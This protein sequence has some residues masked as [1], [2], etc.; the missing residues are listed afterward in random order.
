MRQ[1][2]STSNACVGVV[3]V[4][5]S[6]LWHWLV[7]ICS[8]VTQTR[9]ADA[10]S[11]PWIEQHNQWAVNPP[12][13]L[14]NPGLLILQIPRECYRVFLQLLLVALLFAAPLEGSECHLKTLGASPSRESSG[15]SQRWFVLSFS[16][17]WIFSVKRKRHTKV[18][19]YILLWCCWLRNTLFLCPSINVLC[20]FNYLRFISHRSVYSSEGTWW[21]KKAERT[22]MSLPPALRS[23]LMWRPTSVKSSSRTSGMFFH[24]WGKSHNVWPLPI[25]MPYHYFLIVSTPSPFS[26]KARKEEQPGHPWKEISRRQTDI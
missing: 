21:A 11:S 8:H 3:V 5:N 4:E 7:S 16:D 15:V 18:G 12:W 13:S 26:G 24:F 6:E 9:R 23:S 10:S 14:S 2:K 22:G 17:C 20:F 1:Q 19:V 25:A